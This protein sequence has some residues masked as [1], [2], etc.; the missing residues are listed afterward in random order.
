MKRIAVWMTILIASAMLPC[1]SVCAE[2]EPLGIYV[3]TDGSDRNPGTEAEPFA[4]LERARNAIRALNRKDGLPP[5]GV[6]VWLRGGVYYLSG[7]FELA[8]EDSGTKSSPIVYRA[9]GEEKVWLS[10]GKKIDPSHFKPVTDP[11]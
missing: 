10:G 9:Y 4:T 11:A 6:T 7:T 2:F 3:A 1:R 8:K 5:R